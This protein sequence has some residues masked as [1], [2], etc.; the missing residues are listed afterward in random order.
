MHE[1][2]RQII[3]YGTQRHRLFGVW[4][5][6]F[7]T[8]QAVDLVMYYSYVILCRHTCFSAQGSPLVGIQFLLLKY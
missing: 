8:K 6:S 3:D 7:C 5:L 1:T 4:N 2:M